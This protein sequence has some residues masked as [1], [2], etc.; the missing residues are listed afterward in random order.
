MKAPEDVLTIDPVAMNVVNRVAPGTSVTGDVNFEG[1][2]LVQGRLG[3]EVQVRGPVIVWNGAVLRGNVKVFGD[4]YV[5]GQLGELGAAAEDTQVECIGTLY[6]ASTG[7]S[8]A[9]VTARHVMLYEGADLQ[10][11][12]HMLR[13][14]KPPPVV[15]ERL[16][17]TPRRSRFQS[18]NV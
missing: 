18:R 17:A 16:E 7:V 5:F 2:V 12:F 13:N 3:G 14:K 9:T 10:G 4:L 8:T 15:S 11:P 6:V 1:G